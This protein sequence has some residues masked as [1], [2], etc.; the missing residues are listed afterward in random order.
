MKSIRAVSEE[1]FSGFLKLVYV[2]KLPEIFRVL[3]F[4][5]ISIMW[6]SGKV[7]RGTLNLSRNSSQIE[8]GGKSPVMI[9][10]AES[11]LPFDELYS[12]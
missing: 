9:L 12:N 8:T 2:E 4:V 3:V 11:S 7:S 6:K 1:E 5:R 10:Y